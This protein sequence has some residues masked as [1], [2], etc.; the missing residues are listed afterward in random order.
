M[1]LLHLPFFCTKYK[2][3]YKI[4]Q[5]K[6]FNTLWSSF[7]PYDVVHVKRCACLVKHCFLIFRIK[8]I[9]VLLKVWNAP[10]ELLRGCTDSAVK[11]VE[12]LWILFFLNTIICFH[13]QIFSLFETL[14]LVG[15]R[16]FLTANVIRFVFSKN[17]IY[18]ADKV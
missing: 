17:K 13:E 16:K 18:L 3:S 7:T 15:T 6:Q 9:F 12:K 8:D 14:H 5:Q 4:G 10:K 1:K 2:S 11:S